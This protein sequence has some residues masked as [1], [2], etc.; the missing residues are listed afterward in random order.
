MRARALL[1]VDEGEDLVVDD[2]DAREDDGVGD[3]GAVVVRGLPPPDEREHV[4]ADG[5]VV[6]VAR[7]LA[8]EHVPRDGVRRRGAHRVNEHLGVQAPERLGREERAAEGLTEEREHGVVARLNEPPHVQRNQAD[9]LLVDSDPEASLR[10]GE[11]LVFGDPVARVY[12]DLQLLVML[13]QR[14]HRDPEHPLAT[15]AIVAVGVEERRDTGLSLPSDE[16]HKREGEQRNQ[17]QDDAEGHE[18]IEEGHYEL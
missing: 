3:E 10:F 1:A 5:W 17:P 8:P 12:H 7:N 18:R 9:A 16:Q 4:G 13:R 15:A 6:H 11:N 2:L 14:L